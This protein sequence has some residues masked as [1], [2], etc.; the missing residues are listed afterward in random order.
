MLCARGLFNLRFKNLVWYW[1]LYMEVQNS[2]E[3]YWCSYHDWYRCLFHRN[4][5]FHRKFGIPIENL[6]LFSSEFSSDILVGSSPHAI[7]S[8]VLCAQLRP[9]SAPVLPITYVLFGT[10]Y[11]VPGSH[12]TVFNTQ[13]R[14]HQ[15]RVFRRVSNCSGEA[16]H[17]AFYP[18]QLLPITVFSRWVLN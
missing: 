3:C 5:Y 2:L 12:S 16:E 1:L 14:C 7:P 9:V 10:F 6:V 17:R 11:S 18:K 15:S 13:V 4:F 8:C